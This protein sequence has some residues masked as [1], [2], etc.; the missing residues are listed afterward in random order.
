MYFKASKQEEKE[1]TG[2]GWAYKF[3]CPCTNFTINPA[4][5]VF[6]V[7]DFS[8]FAVGYFSR[9]NAWGQDVS[10]LLPMECLTELLPQLE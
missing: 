4:C 8:S 5:D 10:C 9:H 2:V 7:L 6:S 1:S 3:T